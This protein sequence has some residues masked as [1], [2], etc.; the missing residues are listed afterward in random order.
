MTANPLAANEPSLICV[1]VL[2]K[3]KRSTKSQLTAM[4]HGQ[5]TGQHKITSESGPVLPIVLP[6]RAGQHRSTQPVLPMIT[7]Y[8]RRSAPNSSPVDH[9]QHSSAE[10]ESQFFA[11][12]LRPS[13]SVN[14]PR[15]PVGRQ[16]AGPDRPTARTEPSG[17]TPTA[18]TPIRAARTATYRPRRRERR[19]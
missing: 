2:P 18:S 17:R 4:D 5:H 1:A 7:T 11:W 12:T 19:P 16:R 6:N 9:G 15:A 13:R 8:S 14:R 10:T 3:P